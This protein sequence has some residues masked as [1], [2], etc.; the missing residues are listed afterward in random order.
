MPID[1]PDIY[2]GNWVPCP[3][4][5][6][7]CLKCNGT[8]CDSG[9]L[10]LLEYENDMNQYWKIESNCDSVR[11][12]SESFQTEVNYDLLYING[13]SFTGSVSIDTVGAAKKT[14][15]AFSF[16]FPSLGKHFS[17]FTF[18]FTIPSE[19][20][21]KRKTQFRFSLPNQKMWSYF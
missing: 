14:C 18:S 13:E 1:V 4:S 3:E 12:Q 5:T 21:W 17:A 19:K 10:E 8:I 11:L 9:E 15:F 2:Y 7:P 6:E 20:R 16:T